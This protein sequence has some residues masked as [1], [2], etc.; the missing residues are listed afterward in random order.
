MLAQHLATRDQVAQADKA[1][2]DAQATLDAL[3]R[4]GGD[5]AVQ[6][7]TAPFDGVVTSIAA[8]QG[9]LVQP[10]A[11]LLTL[12]R[13]DRMAVVV[14]LD[15]A[16]RP[17]VHAGEPVR[18]QPETA[19]GTALAGKVEQVGAM[20]DPKTRLVDTVIGIPPGAAVVGAVYRAV[21]TVGQYQG[22][23]V[24]RDAVLSDSKGAYVFQV[25]GGKA[26][27]V[28]VR[29]IGTQR[30]DHRGARADRGRA[31]KLVVQGNYQLSDGMAVRLDGAA[32]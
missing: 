3:R 15:P 1:V 25:A 8:A 6:T 11:P 22:W 12:A 27:R 23:T 14:G 2:T 13:S 29:V 24:P 5:Q 21:I 18:L 30:P 16:D 7:V 31:R 32:S 9:A 28:D 26:V 17:K 10:N 4:E 19:G 20:I